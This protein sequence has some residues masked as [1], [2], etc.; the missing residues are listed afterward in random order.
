MC[1]DFAGMKIATTTLDASNKQLVV[2]DVDHEL[3]RRRTK[4][5]GVDDDA[6]V[7]TLP[8]AGTMGMAADEKTRFG[9]VGGEQAL[10][11]GGE[12]LPGAKNPPD[13]IRRPQG[14]GDKTSQV[15]ETLFDGLMALRNSAGG[16]AVGEEERLE[17]IGGKLHV[18]ARLLHQLMSEFGVLRPRDDTTVENVAV[19]DQHEAVGV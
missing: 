4:G 10:S 18:T 14:I 3:S 12:L 6:T 5:T 16:F 15:F 17:G 13:A 1:N 8:D 11:E 19:G 7:G 2:L 9:V